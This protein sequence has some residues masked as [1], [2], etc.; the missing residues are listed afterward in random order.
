MDSRSQKKNKNNEEEFHYLFNA[1]GNR[2]SSI[3]DISKINK[4]LIAG[5]EKYNLVPLK[6]FTPEASLKK[7]LEATGVN[8]IIKHACA[9]WFEKN[10]IPVDGEF[11]DVKLATKTVKMH[12]PQTKFSEKSPQNLDL[13]ES[14][15]DSP[16][17]THLQR[18]SSQTDE[19]VLA[20]IIESTIE[21]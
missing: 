11:R 8:S 19:D 21:K 2:I 16:I 17:R 18:S 3:F 10:S 7:K 9:D 15:R 14:F 12:E 1:D 13:S 5:R 6:G 20:K 4:V